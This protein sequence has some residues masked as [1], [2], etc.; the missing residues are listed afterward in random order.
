MPRPNTPGT[1]WVWDESAK[2]LTSVPVRLG[3]TNGQLTELI[4]GDIK[5][6]QQLVTNVILPQTSTASAQQNSLFNTT[7]AVAGGGGPPGG[8]RGF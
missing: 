2:T 8:G 5:V 3:I 1:V 6:G 4:D 7:A